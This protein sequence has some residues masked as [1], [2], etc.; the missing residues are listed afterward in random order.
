MR[1]K[2]YPQSWVLDRT[3]PPRKQPRLSQT[4]LSLFDSHQKFVG[5]WR[6]D[7]HSEAVDRD[8]RRFANCKATVSCFISLRY[9]ASLISL[10][11]WHGLPLDSSASVKTAFL[12]RLNELNEGRRQSGV[13]PGFL[14]SC[15]AQ[16]RSAGLR[17]Q[18]RRPKRD[19][20]STVSR[21]QPK[22]LQIVGIFYR[23]S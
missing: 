16:Q 20:Y 19:R 3:A 11:R 2:D 13:Q 22:W 12:R 8:E 14:C 4:A 15:L 10:H 23:Q 5:W 21:V 1:W 6:P 9:V 18:V 7:M 17:E